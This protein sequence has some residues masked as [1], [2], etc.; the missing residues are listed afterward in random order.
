MWPSFLLFFDKDGFV[1]LVEIL[2][3]L[4]RNMDI[5]SVNSSGFVLNIVSINVS[6]TSESGTEDD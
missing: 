5:C 1:Y 3:D 4:F 6:E 2:L